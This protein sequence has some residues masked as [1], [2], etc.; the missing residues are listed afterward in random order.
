MKL[1]TMIAGTALAFT[2][3][4][5][6]GG[7]DTVDS[8]ASDLTLANVAETTLPTS[9]EA[10]ATTLE[11]G[12]E[13]DS[14]TASASPLPTP[15]TNNSAPVAG[16]EA[17]SGETEIAVAAAA[18]FTTT[19]TPATTATAA[20]VTTAAPATTAAPVTVTNNCS[21]ANSLVLKGNTVPGDV[22]MGLATSPETPRNPCGDAEER[23]CFNAAN[24]ERAKIGLTPF[25]WD[26]DLADLGRSHSADM[27]QRDYFEH[28]SST[29]GSHLYQQRGD[30]LGLKNGK[31]SSVVENIAYGSNTGVG[32]VTQFM[33]SSGLRAV[34]LG[35]EYWGG[36]THM[37]CGRDGNRWSMEFAW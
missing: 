16:A 7:D 14:L 36:V 20:P 28:G 34:I 15:L 24:A 30:F 26:G 11:V 3:A 2:V 18:S 19:A 35:E 22:A 37:A 1:W 17:S 5:C 27:N 8:L 13:T 31:F 4:S 6:G 29:T 33:N 10:N 32:T 9:A 25:I 21:D 23:A 12:D